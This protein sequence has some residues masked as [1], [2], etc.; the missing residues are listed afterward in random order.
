MDITNYKGLPNLRKFSIAHNLI[1]T[2]PNLSSCPQLK[3]LRINDN[4]IQKIPEHIAEC[5]GLS[6]LYSLPFCFNQP[7]SQLS[8][9]DL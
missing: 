3:E 5:S 7:I 4:K 2:I 9:N 1:K 8:N 6:F